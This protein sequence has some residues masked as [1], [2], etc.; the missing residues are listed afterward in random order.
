MSRR[1]GAR[2]VPRTQTGFTLIELMASL[3]I[4]LGITA[5]ALSFYVSTLGARRSIDGRLEL[6][7]SRYFV[8]QVLG[9]Y[10]L[11]AGHRP[12]RPE[13]VDGA[14]LPVRAAAQAFP[15]DAGWA[16]GESL[17]PVAAGLAI[18]YV[19]SSREN[20][21]GDLVADGSITD[22]AGARLNGDERGGMDFTLA[23][24]ALTCTA[25]GP[26]AVGGSADGAPVTRVTLAGDGDGARSADGVRI[27]G[28]Y[29]RVAL[30]DDGDASAER[31]VRLDT[32]PAGDPGEPVAVELHLLVASPD[33]T[34]QAPEGFTF[35]GV[36]TVPMDTRLRRES[37]YYVALRNR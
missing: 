27:E 36:D 32:R 11:Q 26:W 35:D 13:L 12:L 28:F 22:C 33:R 6:Q 30:D 14:L 23:D 8:G 31:T 19:G 2:V 15:A 4:G 20:A 16:A 3:A 29:A 34:L 21:A 25:L 18:R 37:L 7:E 10:L 24:G 1:A 5:T 17:R 9:Q